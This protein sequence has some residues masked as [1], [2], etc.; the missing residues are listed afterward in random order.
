MNPASADLRAAVQERFAKVAVSPAGEQK[1][2]IGPAS[3]KKLGYNPADIDALPISAT[4][5][6]CGVSNP[7]SLGEISAGQTVL[8]LGS[9]A[10]MDGLLAARRVGPD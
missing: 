3:A 7:L 1:F 4:E 6:F 10:G 5:S 2:P 8:D 9:G